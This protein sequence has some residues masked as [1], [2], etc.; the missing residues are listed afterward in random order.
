MM[1]L[2]I[3]KRVGKAPCRLSEIHSEEK[4]PNSAEQGQDNRESER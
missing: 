3:F 2:N 1:A 4:H